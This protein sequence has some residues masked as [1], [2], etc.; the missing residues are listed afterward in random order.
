MGQK[1]RFL[2]GIGA[3]VAVAALQP[4]LEVEIPFNQPI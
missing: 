3:A 4:A 1:R 2:M